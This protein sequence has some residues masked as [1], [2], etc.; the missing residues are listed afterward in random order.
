MT[1]PRTLYR[2]WMGQLLLVLLLWLLLCA[3]FPGNRSESDDGYFYALMLRDADIR[4]LF[5]SKYLLYLPLARLLQH[6]YEWIV[7][8]IDAYQFLRG[9]SAL[10]AAAS[11]LQFYKLLRCQLRLSAEASYMGVVALFGCYGFWRYAVEAEVYALAILAALCWLRLVLRLAEA[12]SSRWYQWLLAGVVGGGIVWLYKPLIVVTAFS[13]SAYL[14]VDRRFWQRWSWYVVALSATVLLGYWVSF[15]WQVAHSSFWSFAMEGTNRGLGSPLK[16][17]LLLGA[18]VVSS[19]FVYGLPGVGEQVARWFP[20]NGIEEEVYLAQHHTGKAWIAAACLAAWVVCLCVALI[21]VLC[22]RPHIDGR[23]R[24]FAA[25]VLMYGIV[26]SLID[27]DGVEPWLLVVPALLV[28][29]LLLFFPVGQ[30]PA[31]VHRAALW[32]MVG[33]LL[34]TNVVGGYLMIRDAA[35]DYS[36]AVAAPLLRNASDR[37]YVL[38]FGSSNTLG[39]LRYYS[40]AKVGLP[41]QA[42]EKSI[43]A[44][45]STLQAGGKVWLLADFVKPAAALQHRNRASW[46]LWKA[47]MQ[48]NEE[49]IELVDGP[50]RGMQLYRLRP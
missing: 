18:N 48:T 2:T 34:A 5:L 13:F 8:P 20:F 43:A 24:F 39:Y 1:F 32:L 12:G 41:E 16:S 25:W 33:L 47:W 37:D 7:G 19:V 26:I 3:S 10:A 29:L 45:D 35:G 30:Q 23:W 21:R 6:G 46:E 28:W 38:S 36:R 9:L 22:R 4:S 17:W 40:T 11:L 31:P 49:R 27:A 44:A 14:L 15:Q 42:F 50:E